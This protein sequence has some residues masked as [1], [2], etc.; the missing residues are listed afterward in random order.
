[1]EVI[2][3]QPNS[4]TVRKAKLTRAFVYILMMTI[5]YDWLGHEFRSGLLEA[6]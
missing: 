5:H 6:S 4:T 2:E 1:M 3:E